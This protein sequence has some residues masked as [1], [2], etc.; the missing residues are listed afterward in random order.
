MKKKRLLLFGLLTLLMAP[1][2][3]C[4]ALFPDW[5]D[6]LALKEFNL[7]AILLGISFGGSCAMII[8]LYSEI[9]E[10]APLIQDQLA[11]VK[12]LKI[13]LFD[14]IF[15]AFCAG[16]GEEMLFR[17]GIQP[18][19]GPWITSILFVAIH[20]YLHPRKWNVTKYGLMVLVFILL[21]SFGK[22]EFGLWFCISAHFGYDFILFYLW[23][24]Q[25]SD[26]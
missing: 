21:I 15:L 3:W 26:T 22:E 13:N 20:G 23:K 6:F 12:S 14:C 5:K 19:L 18:Y 24:D 7:P 8:H 25:N 11:L 16:F 10:N 2:G 17:A 4:I 9:D 1:L